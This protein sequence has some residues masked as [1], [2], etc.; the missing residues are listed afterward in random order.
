MDAQASISLEELSPAIGRLNVLGMHLA[1]GIYGAL[2]ADRDE[3]TPIFEWP[4]ACAPIGSV[5]LK[6]KF[7]RTFGPQA[8]AESAEET[9]E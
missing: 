2:T 9:D 4:L 6:R 3:F 5:V 1:T 8:A 7:E